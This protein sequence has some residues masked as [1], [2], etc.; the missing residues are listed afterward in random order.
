ME[1][2]QSYSLQEAEQYFAKALNGEVWELLGKADRTALDDE[3]MLY[4]AYASCYHWLQVGTAVHQQR[5][6]WLIA[7]VCTVLGTKEEALRHAS[8]C[9]ELTQ[10]YAPLMQDFDKAF[11]FEAVARANALAGNHEAAAKYRRLAAEAGD[12]I[13]DAED[14]SIFV[15]DFNGGNWFGAT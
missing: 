8:R 3:R 4:A 2:K 15:G 7:R 10:Q 13:A 9:L 14:K 12:L 11:A 5:G 1:E 6:E